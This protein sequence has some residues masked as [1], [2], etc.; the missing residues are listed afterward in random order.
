MHARYLLLVLAVSCGP[1]APV[2]YNSPPP[3]QPPPGYQAAAAPWYCFT[4]I[5]F[6]AECVREEPHCTN[7][8]NEMRGYKG[9]QSVSAC[10][11]VQTVYCH[12]FSDDPNSHP[13]CYPTPEYCENGRQIMASAGPQSACVTSNGGL[14]PPPPPA[15]RMAAVGGGGWWCF[16]TEPMNSECVPEQAHCTRDAAE[17]R[18]NSVVKYVSECGPTHV[19]YCHQYADDP[20]SHPLCYPSPAYCQKGREIMGESSQTRCVRKDV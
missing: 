14:V 9:V 5:P 8:A 20:N 18:G 11:A 7:D 6:N 19:L 12:Q 15:P 2:Q 10:Q 17:M 16:T 13:L 3:Q 1:P 4:S